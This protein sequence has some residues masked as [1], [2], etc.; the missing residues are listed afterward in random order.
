VE[1]L[2]ASDVPLDAPGVS[3]VACD[4]R[5]PAPV[6]ERVL[7]DGAGQIIFNFGADRPRGERGAELPCHAGGA[8]LAPTRIV[9]HGAIDQL[10]VR[11]GVGAVPAVLGVPA[12]ALGDHGVALDALWGAFAA[13]T[14]ERL[15]AIPRGRPRA[16][17]L[18]RLLDERVRRAAPPPP[19]AREAVRRIAAAG[20]R[21]G[22]TRLAA[23]LGVGER[24]LQ[25]LFHAHVGLT[26]RALCRLARF[27]ALLARLRAHPGRPWSEVALDAGFYDQSHLVNEVRAFTGF[28]PREL[29]G[30]PRGDF[31]FFQDGAARAS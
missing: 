10:C 26:P 29:A 17:R 12:G 27:R 2:Y 16:A 28:T 7:P 21:I 23:D 9:L 24:R 5:Y 19:A 20:G 11:L 6:A 1:R 14:L 30:A 13:D 3:I 22:V 18:A 8:S 25:Q 15:A 31:G 4:E